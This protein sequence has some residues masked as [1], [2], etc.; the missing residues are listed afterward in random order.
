M[1]E[2]IIS[3]VDTGR[4]QR[5]TFATRDE[6]S[7]FVN[8]QQD[9]WSARGLSARGYRIEIEHHEPPVVLTVPQLPAAA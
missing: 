1:F 2:V 7:R 3:T 6:A 8:Q 9:R 5:R 4:V